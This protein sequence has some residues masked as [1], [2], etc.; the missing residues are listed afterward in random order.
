MSDLQA[1]LST[2]M[3]GAAQLRRASER[4]ENSLINTRT[5]VDMLVASGYESAASVRLIEQFR[6]SAARMDAMPSLLTQLAQRLDT[7]TADIQGALEAQ[8]PPPVIVVSAAVVPSLTGAVTVGYRRGGRWQNQPPLHVTTTTVETVAPVVTVTPQ[9]Y[10]SRV[11]RALYDQWAMTRAE[12]ESAA[13]LRDDLLAQRISKQQELNALTNRILTFNASADLTK[14]HRVGLLT[15]DIAALDTH[16]ADAN[17]HIAAID[18][19]LSG[20]A[21]RLQR[22]TPP[23]GADATL[24]A[25]MEIGKTQDNVVANT[26]SCVNYV[27]KHINVPANLAVDA[28]KWDEAVAKLPQYGMTRGTVPLAGSVL[29]MEREHAY[30]DPINGHVMIVERVD[31]VGNI[32]VS[33]NLHPDKPVMLSS[34]TDEISG[35]NISYVYFPW[36]TK[37]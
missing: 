28:Y 6:L 9:S 36:N 8:L 18:T 26:Y 30:A 15:S 12:S 29:V 34:L 22:V 17:T 11:N 5:A 23:V 24:I 16:I 1:R 37:A 4:V 10:V 32:W 35:K 27:V 2:L 31:A 19:R 20:L 13:A 21:E 33:D 3:T 25:Q 7:A 14:V